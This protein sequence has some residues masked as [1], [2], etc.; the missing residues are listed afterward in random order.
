[1]LEL[2]PLLFSIFFNTIL[3]IQEVG[4]EFAHD[5]SIFMIWMYLYF[6]GF[7]FMEKGAE[8]VNFKNKQKVPWA[9]NMIFLSNKK[10]S[11]KAWCP[12]DAPSAKRK[13]ENALL[14]TCNL[15]SKYWGFS[16]H[17]PRLKILKYAHIYAGA[18]FWLNENYYFWKYKESKYWENNPIHEEDENSLILILKRS[19]VVFF[20][21]QWVI[22]NIQFFPYNKTRYCA[23]IHTQNENNSFF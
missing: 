19:E 11:V 16:F 7:L 22:P 23:Y 21:L 20:Y 3:K 14:G 18:H 9:L 17:V 6:H 1:M 13:V 5:K 2:F 4:P 10:M 12:F 8:N 15:I